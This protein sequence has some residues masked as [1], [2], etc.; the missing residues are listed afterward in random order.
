M[1][2]K[3]LAAAAK[4]DAYCHQCHHPATDISADMQVEDIAI[5]LE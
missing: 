4:R 2:R 1:E 3:H 5:K